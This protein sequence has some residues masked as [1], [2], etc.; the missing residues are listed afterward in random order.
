M[1]VQPGEDHVQP[2]LDAVAHFRAHPGHALVHLP[3]PADQ[4]LHQ[5]DRALGIGL[6][7]GEEGVVGG[8]EALGIGQ[9]LDGGGSR[10]GVDQAHLAED[11]AGL[12]GADGLGRVARA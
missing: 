5:L 6:R 4:R 12:Q 2:L 8:H 11:L 9:R 1:L 10:P 3:Q 7:R